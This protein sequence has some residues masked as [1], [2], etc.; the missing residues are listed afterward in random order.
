MSKVNDL[1]GQKFGRLTVESFAGK[2]SRRYATWLCQC[3]CGNKTVVCG[4][5]LRSGN[6]KS[7]GCYHDEVSRDRHKRHGMCHTKLYY[8]WV[9][10]RGRCFN[11]NNKSYKNYGGRGITVCDEWKDS[12]SAFY[13][14]ALSNGYK[15]G[16]SIDRIKNNSDYSPE[17]CRWTTQKVQNN[18]RRSNHFIEFNGETHTISEWAAKLGLTNRT[19]EKRISKGEPIEKAFGPPRR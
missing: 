18:N 16:L 6:T 7:C 19:L 15:D 4:S 13:D 12:F 11:P 3:D 8:V 10:M 1:T 2:N 14:W 9:G 17:N 5:D